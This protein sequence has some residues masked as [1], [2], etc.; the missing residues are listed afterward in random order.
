[1]T[2][3][4]VLDPVLG[5]R[6]KVRIL[7]LLARTRG[8]RTGREIARQTGLSH[9]ASHLALRD[10]ERHGILLKVRAGRAYLFALNEEHVLVS[11]V[12]IPAFDTEAAFVEKYAEA[13]R[14]GLKV[15]IESA[16][17][18]GSV[19]RGT[20]RPE[21]DV[22]LMFIVRDRQAAERARAQLGPLASSLTRR[23]GRVPQIVFSDART[24]RRNVRRRNPYYS[25]VIRDGRI[26][27]GKPL[28]ELLKNGS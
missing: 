26:L 8:Q 27:F 5:Q 10:L 28:S 7:R 17:L 4:G 13:A 19:A 18:Y 15:P 24:F 16:I 3:S 23:F 2:L 20:E 22:D 1:M 6:S 25:A 14:K 21:S 11:E 12:L 9:R